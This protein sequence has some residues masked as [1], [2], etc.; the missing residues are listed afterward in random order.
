MP[1]HNLF[2]IVGDVYPSYIH[3]TILSHETAHTT[4]IISVVGELV[5]AEAVHVGVE[6]VVRPWQAVQIVT[7]LPVRAEPPRKPRAKVAPGN[8]VGLCVS[9]VLDNVASALGLRL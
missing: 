2:N 1:S 3:R 8:L 4:H 5:A 7:I 6:E 9:A